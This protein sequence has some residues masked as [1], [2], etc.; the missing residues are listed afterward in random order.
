MAVHMDRINPADEGSS[1][2]FISHIFS[3]SVD[4]KPSSI[5]SALA[6]D[7]REMTLLCSWGGKQ[8]TGESRPIKE[9]MI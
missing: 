3:A 6:R 7:Q 1:F 9:Y 2:V 5:S 8:I 4:Q